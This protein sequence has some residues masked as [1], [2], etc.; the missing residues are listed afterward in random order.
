MDVRLQRRDAVGR[1]L[2]H[3]RGVDV[4]ILHGQLPQL[5]RAHCAGRDLHRLYALVGELV[6]VNRGLEVGDLAQRHCLVLLPQRV[7]LVARHAH[8]RV[9]ARAF[10]DDPH[11]VVEMHGL[12]VGVLFVLFCLPQRHEVHVQPHRGQVHAVVGKI[13]LSQLRELRPR[14]RRVVYALL[15]DFYVVLHRLRA[16]DGIVADMRAVYV[17]RALQQQRLSF[18]VLPHGDDARHQ[19]V[20]VRGQR[21]PKQVF[22]VADGH[23]RLARKVRQKPDVEVVADE[24]SIRLRHDAVVRVEQALHQPASRVLPRHRACE[25]AM[26]VESVRVQRAVE[27]LLHH[28]PRSHALRRVLVLRRVAQ[29]VV[30]DVPRLHAHLTLR[31]VPLHLVD[32]EQLHAR[33][34]G[35]HHPLRRRRVALDGLRLVAHIDEILHAH[36]ARRARRAHDDLPPAVCLRKH[37][38]LRARAVLGEYLRRGARP[39]PQVQIRPRICL[40]LVDFACHRHRF[41][42]YLPVRVLVRQRRLAHRR[43]RLDDAAHADVQPLPGLVHGV[44][45]A[46]FVH[47]AG[48]FLDGALVRRQRPQ[49]QGGKVLRVRRVDGDHIRPSFQ[50]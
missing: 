39:L 38:H 43:G 30:K 25:L 50:A 17:G 12:K 14:L 2:L 29:Q 6:A 23:A 16:D 49:A 32:A 9:D 41:F 1:K 24:P 48:L 35:V 13:R 46:Q 10:G 19:A 28:R 37:D 26:Y 31:R 20:P 33:L 18:L 21:R 15:P 45:H 27:Q 44:G 40:H 8:R 7:P 47:A 5:R 3:R 36:V 42:R 34:H 4:R 11:R 22:A